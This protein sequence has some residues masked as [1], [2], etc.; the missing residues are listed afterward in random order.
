MLRL[1]T[2][3]GFATISIPAISSWIFGFPKD[4]C[5]KILWSIKT[6]FARRT[7]FT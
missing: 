6:I 2:Q 4:N 5:A 1:T 7:Y 3:D